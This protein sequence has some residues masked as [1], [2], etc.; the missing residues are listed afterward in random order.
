MNCLDHVWEKFAEISDGYDIAF[1]LLN[2]QENE[3]IAYGIECFEFVGEAEKINRLDSDVMIVAEDWKKLYILPLVEN[4]NLQAFIIQ[5]VYSNVVKKSFIQ[6]HSSFICC[7]GKGILFLGPSGI[8]KTTQA[9]LW[10]RYRNALIVNGDIVFVQE[11]KE[12][13]LGWGTP[14]HGSSPY[15]EN[16][17]AAIH[18]IVVLK[19]AEKNSIRSLKEFEKVAEAANSIFYPKWL[20][21]GMELCLETLHHLLSQVPV[22]ELS[23]RADEEAVDITEKMIFS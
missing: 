10:S 19:Q 9:E 17:S 1:T 16:T 23:C 6:L 8:G 11:T 14:W 15:S 18:A 21:E 20:E 3:R 12:G 22:Y 4:T 5:A 7:R 2:Y 13:F